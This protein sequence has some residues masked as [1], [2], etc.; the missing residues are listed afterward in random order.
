MALGIGTVVRL[1]EIYTL[2]HIK[3]LPKSHG[4]V[5]FYPVFS[6]PDVVKKVGSVK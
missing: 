2:L 3:F 1:S 6:F 5:I 4:W